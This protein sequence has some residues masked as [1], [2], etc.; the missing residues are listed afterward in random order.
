MGTSTSDPGPK[1]VNPLL[2][3]WAEPALPDDDVPTPSP[4]E[5]LPVE[6]GPR[7]QDPFAPTLS[8][9]GAAVS[10]NTPRIIIGK[11]A[12]GPSAGRRNRDTRRAIRA[13]VQALGGGRTAARG[14]VAGRATGARFGNFL[15]AVGTRGLQEAA[16]EFG[17][18]EYLG[19]SADVFLARLADTLAPAGG[20]TE[21][22]IARAAMD[23]TLEELY[24]IMDLANAGVDGLQQLTPQIMADLMMR[25]VIN[26]VY[27]RVLQA[28]AS[29]LET[30]SPS[31]KRVAEVERDARRYI[32]AVV[33]A[34]L[35]QTNVAG[36]APPDFTARWDG[37]G[38]KLAADRLFVECFRVVEAGLTDDTVSRRRTS[39]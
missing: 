34:D 3:P 29:H 18:Q 2:P 9:L 7:P 20:L 4:T 6:S 15:S 23:A 14:A 30:R 1:G 10:W 8:N 27:E 17:V 11:A 5:E 25:Y 31:P 22:A 32:D 26:Y 21:D 38:S 37:A 12:N 28:L 33:R 19:R 13:T 16:R 35:D 39:R 24:D 36:A